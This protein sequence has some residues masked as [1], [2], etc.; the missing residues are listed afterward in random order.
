MAT[1]PSDGIHGLYQPERLRADLL[2]RGEASFKGDLQEIV[3]AL[4]SDR[5]QSLEVVRHLH[6]GAQLLLQGEAARLAARAPDDPRIAALRAGAARAI[7]QSQLLADEATLASVRIPLVRKTEALL[8]GRVTDDANRPAGPLTVTLV[9]EVGKPVEG[10]APVEADSAGYYALV[11]PA[12]VASRLPAAGRYAVA[13]QHGAERLAP[14]FEPQPL[15]A[16]AVHL[17]DVT[18]SEEDLRKLKV[19][20]EFPE[21]R[22]RQAPPAKAPAARKGPR[23]PAGGSHEA[24]PHHEPTPPKEPAPSKEPAPPKPAPPHEPDD[25]QDPGKGGHPR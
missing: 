13:L 15:K 14:R 6:L 16:G 4:Q 9:D 10:V 3:E 12:D 22:P 11:V 5:Q 18:L 20:A 7:D 17:E 8:H 21:L 2:N 1:N 19:R 25:P 24:Q 23:S